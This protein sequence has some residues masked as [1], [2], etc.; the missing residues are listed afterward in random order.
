MKKYASRMLNLL[1]IISVVLTMPWA[2]AEDKSSETI[3]KLKVTYPLTTCVV[4]GEKLSSMGGHDY[5]Y[6]QNINGA[7]TERLVRFCCK[8]CIKEFNKNP[9][10]YLKMIDDANKKK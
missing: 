8:G 4:T 9:E 7:E 3:E 10:K 1:V 6:K 5:L 2:M